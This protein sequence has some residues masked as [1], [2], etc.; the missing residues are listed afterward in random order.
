MLQTGIVEHLA[1]PPV[2]GF[3]SDKVNLS[4]AAYRFGVPDGPIALAS[5]AANIPLAALGSANR[6]QTQPWLS[7]AAAAKAA[8][9]AVVASWYFYQMPAREKAWCAYCITAALASIAVFALTV[10][11]AA[12]GWRAAAGAPADASS[13]NCG[14]FGDI[15]RHD[16]LET[17]AESG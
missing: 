12:K 6:A 9:E 11:E 8:I 17:L 15:N 4:D 3:D 14:T 5:F 2:R 13:V 10:P 1:D 7:A 16:R